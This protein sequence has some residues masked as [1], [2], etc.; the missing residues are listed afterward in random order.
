MESHIYTSPEL[1]RIV[2]IVGDHVPIKVRVSFSHESIAEMALFSISSLD[3]LSCV[4]DFLHMHSKNWRRNLALII[5]ADIHGA[6][7]LIYRTFAT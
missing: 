4:R 6:D 3:L 5:S 1:T 2:R 7:G